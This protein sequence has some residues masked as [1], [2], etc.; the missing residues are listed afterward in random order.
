MINVDKIRPVAKTKARIATNAVLL[1]YFEYYFAY[2]FEYSFV[3][4]HGYQITW[5]CE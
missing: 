5:M 3:H 4:T 1:L 2:Y